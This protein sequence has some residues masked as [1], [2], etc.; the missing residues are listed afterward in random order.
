MPGA[1]R[2]KGKTKSGLILLVNILKRARERR[3]LSQTALAK[4]A[5][6]AVAA[7]ESFEACDLNAI[8]LPDVLSIAKALGKELTVQLAPIKPRLPQPNEEILREFD[9][10]MKSRQSMP[11]FRGQPDKEH[12]QLLWD[13]VGDKRR[14]WLFVVVGHRRKRRLRFGAVTDQPGGWSIGGQLFGIDVET[15]AIARRMSRRL[16][17]AHKGELTGDYSAP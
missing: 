4:R 16:F 13:V 10:L 7:V 17:K 11:F 2:A 14:N 8:G 1:N 3:R 12:E 6:V 5:G 9:S 15:D